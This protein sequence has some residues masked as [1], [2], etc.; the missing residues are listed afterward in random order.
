MSNRSL[1]LPFVVTIAT[2]S[3]CGGT[4]V[5]D[6]NSGSGGTSQSS[7]S[8]SSAV[9]T[10][11]GP[12]TSTGMNITCPADPPSGYDQCSE[13]PG[14]CVY[15]V[16]CQSGV[17]ALSF[18]CVDGWW[19]LEPTPCAQPYD[20][21]PGTEYY[22]DMAWW[23]PTGSNPPTPCPD[24]LPPAGEM[25]FTGGMGGVWENCGYRCGPQPN[26]SWTVA[27]CVMS[28]TGGAWQYDGACGG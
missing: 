17:V 5:I 18:S 10:G 4:A 8:S 25:C 22:C 20:S 19:S 3:A 16:P 12:S 1:R 7:S 11:S 13:G 23:M 14:N 9:S 21:C 2:A 26:A 15:D 27:T 24:I 6:G 28:P